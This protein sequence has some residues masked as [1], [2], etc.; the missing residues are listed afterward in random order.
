M[1]RN[2]E[3]AWSPTR[4]RVKAVLSWIAAMLPAILCLW[5]VWSRPF[6]IAAESPEASAVHRV[7]PITGTVAAIADCGR[8]LVEIRSI[9]LRWRPSDRDLPAPLQLV[10]EGESRDR[11]SVDRF[12][13]RLASHEFL[14]GVAA[15]RSDDLGGGVEF[16]IRVGG[17][18]ASFPSSFPCREGVRTIVAMSE[19]SR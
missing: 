13:A 18:K 2:V 5:A 16:E 4:L 8:D 6:D 17:A 1:G 14:G 15:A 3:S 7:V 19:R 11:A 12:T 9:R 10:V